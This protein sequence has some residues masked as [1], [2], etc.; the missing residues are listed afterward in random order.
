MAINFEHLLTYKN[1][2]AVKIER[3]YPLFLGHN[4]TE[5]DIQR[6]NWHPKSRYDTPCPATKSQQ[7]N[8]TPKSLTQCQAQNGTAKRPVSGV[9]TACFEA[10]H[11]PFH[12]PT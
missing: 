1:G 2:N 4:T 12:K 10:R 7:R 5:K 9:K 8:V 11:G 6:F 3:Q